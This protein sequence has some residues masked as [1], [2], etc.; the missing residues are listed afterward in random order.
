MQLLF[1][2][3]ERVEL[4]IE[5]GLLKDSW[6]PILKYSYIKFIYTYDFRE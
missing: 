5:D 4:R 1:V 3:F 6:L 2:G